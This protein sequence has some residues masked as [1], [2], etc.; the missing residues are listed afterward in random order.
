MTDLNSVLAA[1]DGSPASY[2]GAAHAI[3]R[4]Q[5]AG[6]RRLRL[7]ILASFTIDFLRPYLV[8]EAAR[9]G[10]ALDLFIGP[11]GQFEQQALDPDSGLLR[12]KP[13]IV[14]MA[15]AVEDAAPRLCDGFL[16]LNGEAVAEEVA[17]VEMRLRSLVEVIR[18]RSGAR[19]LVANVSRRGEAAGGFA[20]TLLAPGQEETLAELNRR[21]AGVCRATSEA[22]IFDLAALMRDVGR[23]NWTDNRLQYFARAPLS[24]AALR[25]MAVRLARYL[26]ALTAPPRKCLVLDLDN[27]LWGGVLGEDGLDGIKLGEDWPGN[28]FKAFQRACLTFRDRGILLAVASKNDEAL[29]LEALNQHADGLIRAEHL[30]CHRINWNDKAT[31]LRDIA[32]ELNIGLD[33]LVFFDDNPVERD[34]VRQSCPEVLVIDVPADP[35]GYIAALEESGAFDRMVLTT[36]DRRRAAMYT[37][38]AQRKVLV[39]GTASMEDFLRQL[40]MKVRLGPFQGDA[41]PRVAQLIAKTNQFNLTGRR[42]SAACL[43]D[44]LKAGAVGLWIRVTDR[45]GDNGLVGVALAVPEAGEDWRLDLFLL[46]CRVIG[47]KIEDTLLTVMAECVRARGGKRIIGEYVPTARNGMAEHFLADAGFAKLPD[48]RWVLDVSAGAPSRS[49]L[50]DIEVDQPD[51][52]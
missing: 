40:D 14:F 10:I 7:A 11:F 37:A 44:A 13:D 19:I 28:A 49:D 35:L 9:R 2:S 31:N 39:K 8:V 17:I 18:S 21:L 41:L 30:S 29:A 33:S 4:L 6:L 26:S 43:E 45:F 27:T 22:Y 32:A 34:W 1:L 20:D 52:V 15:M 36:D 47:R 38:E 24:T 3:G 46:S 50:I 5:D 51:Y 23:R 48:G 25:A 42:R 12:F 16:A